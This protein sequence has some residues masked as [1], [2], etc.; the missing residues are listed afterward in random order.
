MNNDPAIVLKDYDVVI[1]GGGM[2]GAILAKLLTAA[3]KRVLVL[4][5]GQAMG[6]RW[7][8][9]VDY[10]ETFY[11]QWLKTDQAPYPDNPNASFPEAFQ[12][13][14]GT[15]VSFGTY[16]SSKPQGFPANYVRDLGGTSLHWLGTSL[17]MLP[18]DFEMATRYG[19]AVDWPIK[20]QDLAPYYSKAEW[21]LG[22]SAEVADQ[23]YLGVE[24]EKD[25]Y[26]PMKR[27]P[28]SFLDTVIS[29]GL[30]G[31]TV[32]FDGK[33][34]PVK[35]VSLPQ[36][37][38]SVPNGDY[39][40]VGAVD[41]AFLGQRCQGM[42]NCVPLCP[43]QAKYSA[44][45]SFNQANPS[46]LDLRP[47]TVANRINIDPATGRI[48]GI[49][50]QN[51]FDTTSTSFRPGLA[52]G[53][54]YVIA[55]HVVETSKLLLAS[56]AANSSGLVGRNLMS[57]PTLIAWGLHPQ[58]L[59]AFRGPAVTSGIES[60]RDGDF[61]KNRAAFRT[62]VGNWGWSY[63]ENSPY[64]NVQDL[65]DTQNMY[66]AALRGKLRSILPRQ[67]S[68][69]FLVE[70]LPDTSNRVTIDNT[71]RDQLGNFR[72]IL[73]YQIDDYTRRGFAAARGL[74]KQI[75]TKLGVE[76]HSKYGSNNPNSFSFDGETYG[77]WAA[78]HFAGA[79][80]M[81]TSKTDSVVNIRQQ[82]WDHPNLYLVGCGSFPT[83]G[84][85]NPSLT[86]AA[87]TVWAAENIAKDLK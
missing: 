2:A 15:P 17:R 62:D 53:K 18:G 44:L 13:N 30:E 68:F 23:M 57:H 70:Q 24:F 8:G 50:F 74:S 36:A 28:P 6:L 87:L 84:T 75:F 20:Y 37:R 55:A 59:C 19:R 65:V 21:E 54:I 10:L 82:T 40:P 35:V 22:V 3:S 69:Q 52:Q 7:E 9:Y 12:K 27:I 38:N 25:Y 5:A 39:R 78:G 79:Y 31:M 66:G 81:G 77:Y 85:S 76:D 46:Y 67:M 33:E 1:V 51:Y 14:N 86:M 64:S 32:D 29:G 83:L 73:N 11:R 47:K 41:V 72:P 71:V 63:P 45:K 42:A 4:E 80:R 34:Y 61:R 26:Y 58:N 43:V 48:T 16:M 56:G 60:L 49:E